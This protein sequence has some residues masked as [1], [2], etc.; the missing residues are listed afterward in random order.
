[1]ALS[2]PLHMTLEKNISVPEIQSHLNN[3]NHEEI[4]SFLEY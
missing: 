4:L 3:F 1:M 2:K